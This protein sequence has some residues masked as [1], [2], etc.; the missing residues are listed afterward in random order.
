MRRVTSNGC[1][2]ADAPGAYAMLWALE[3]P[4]E[5]I[6]SRIPT[7]VE[8]QGGVI[9]FATDGVPITAPPFAIDEGEYRDEVLLRDS[10]GGVSLTALPGGVVDHTGMYHYRTESPCVGVD[11]AEGHSLLIAFM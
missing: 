10:C 1:P 8:G 2:T 9:G 6:L 3:M 4:Q 7:S 11:L 5:P